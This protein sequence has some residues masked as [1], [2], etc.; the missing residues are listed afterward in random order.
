LA[1]FDLAKRSRILHAL[2]KGQEAEL[3]KL[4]SRAALEVSADPAVPTLNVG[5][6]TVDPIL[7][8]KTRALQCVAPLAGTCKVGA[9]G[10]PGCAYRA[11]PQ[12]ASHQRVYRRKGVNA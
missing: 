12:H 11:A 9:W 2:I 8:A 3:I 7:A 5:F 10:L 1:G 6:R 4:F